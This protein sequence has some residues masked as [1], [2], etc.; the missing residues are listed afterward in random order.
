MLTRYPI[1]IRKAL[2]SN[3]YE[4]A[5]IQRWNDHNRPAI[6]FSEL[7]KQAHKMVYAYI[8]AKCEGEGNYD[9]LL[10]IEGGIF[11]FLHR[12]ILTDIKPP[13]YHS[14]MKRKGG[15]INEWVLEQLRGECEGIGGGFYKK[16]C[17][18]FTEPSYAEKEKQLLLAGHYYATEWE[19]NVI[20]PMNT[21]TFG[22]EEVKAEI[23]KGVADCNTFE[24]YEK[25]AN[26]PD[27]KRFLSLIGKLRYQQRWSRAVRMPQTFVMGHMLVV[28]MLTYFCSVERGHSPR[29]VINNYFSALFHDMPE[30]L[31]RDIV[32]PVK[33]S[34]SGLEDII[35]E[36]EDEQMRKV[37]YPLVP[38]DIKEELEYYTQNE[39]DSRIILG[40]E[41]KKVSSEEIDKNYNDDKF[42]PVDGEI[43]RACDHL[44]AYLEAYMS[45]RFGIQSEQL[46]AGYHNLFQRYQN[47]VI[48]GIDFGQL[49]DYFRL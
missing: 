44:S 48:A 20:Y 12:V 24:G 28:A 42:N 6:G 9:P 31:T 41:V 39:F 30:V 38:E 14:L 21:E 11:E 26:N 15:Q 25:F 45:I 2:I 49:F 37:I 35:K 10:L 43:V 32:S 22:I 18:Y 23:K 46:Q 36:I 47:K 1:M 19:F 4:A 17:R 33:N 3:I 16:M 13:I 7:D 29:R 8:L 40:G 5:S 34:V 27:L